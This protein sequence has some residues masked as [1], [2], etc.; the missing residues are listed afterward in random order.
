MARARV[1]DDGRAERVR[2]VDAR[3]RVR[4]GQGQLAGRRPDVFRHVRVGRRDCAADLCQQRQ[5]ERLRVAQGARRRS[6]GQD[7]HRPL[8][9]S[10]QLSRLQGADRRAVRGEGAAHLL[11]SARGRRQEGKDVPRRPVGPGESYTARGD[12]LRLHRPRRPA[13]AGVGVRRRRQADRRV[14]VARGTEGHCRAALGARCAGVAR[15]ARR[16]ADAGLM[17]RR[18]PRRRL[19]R[20]RWCG[21]RAR[22]RADG[23][24]DA[25]DLER[26]GAHHRGGGTG[27]DRDHRQS[28]GRVG[29]WRGGSEQRHGDAARTRARARRPGQG[30]SSSAPDD[31]AREL[32]CG[33]VAS[34][35]LDRVGRGAREGV[36]RERRRVPE[37]RR[38]DERRAVHDERRRQPQSS[39][40]GDG[41]RR[42]R[43]GGAIGA[44][45]VDGEVEEGTRAG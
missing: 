27:A 12:Q 8:F 13:H 17:A 31:R 22:E 15:C 16:T 40:G 4:R 28:S 11:R 14:G 24:E 32:G 5:P 44:R 20:R 10:V 33:R 2:G 34:H 1:G 42:R 38:V 18:D 25:T 43:P 30:R 26:R 6:R 45:S 39:G 3:G 7:R 19:S 21:D 29:L 23:R 37:C 41:A 9:Q 36:E 35:G